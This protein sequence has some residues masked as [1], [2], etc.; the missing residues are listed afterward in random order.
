[1]G[2]VTAEQADEI[3]KTKATQQW[4]DISRAFRNFDQDGN[5]IVTKKELKNILY[6]FQLSLTQL[7]F[8]KLWNWLVHEIKYTSTNDHENTVNRVRMTIR[9]R[10]IEL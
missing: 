5:G 8:D 3:M 6:R 4:D 2:Y 10:L 9:T 7:E 1:M